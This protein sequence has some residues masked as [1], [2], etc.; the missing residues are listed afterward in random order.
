MTVLTKDDLLGAPTG[1]MIPLDEAGATGRL[2]YVRLPKGTYNDNREFPPGSALIARPNAYNTGRVKVLTPGNQERDFPREGG[3]PFD[4]ERERKMSYR[5]RAEAYKFIPYN[6]AKP[7]IGKPMWPAKQLFPY[8]PTDK[9]VASVEHDIVPGSSR[10]SKRDSLV[11][12]VDGDDSRRGFVP[13]RETKGDLA[14]LYGMGEEFFEYGGPARNTESGVNEH[15]L[16]TLVDWDDQKND[17]QLN[18]LGAGMASRIARKIAHRAIVRARNGQFSALDQAQAWMRQHAEEVK[19]RRIARLDKAIVVATEEAIKIASPKIE[20]IIKMKEWRAS[21]PGRM[22]DYLSDDNGL[23]GFKFGG[24]GKGFSWVKG[25]APKPGGPLANRGKKRKRGLFG[26]LGDLLGL[27]DDGLDGDDEDGLGKFKFG[28][29]KKRPGQMVSPQ[30]VTA[31]V[32]E[33]TDQ[34]TQV[35]KRRRKKR[36]FFGIGSGEEYPEYADGGDTTG[37]TGADNDGFPY[38]GD[39]DSLSAFNFKRGRGFNWGRR[40]SPP[41]PS[42]R[43]GR[44]GLF[45]LGADDD[46]KAGLVTSLS[47]D[48]K[49]QQSITNA[50]TGAVTD[51]IKSGNISTTDQIVGAIGTAAKIGTDVYAAK[52]AAKYAPKSVAPAPSMMSRVTTTVLAPEQPLWKRPLFWGGMALLVGAGGFLML[53]GGKKGKGTRRRS[54]RNALMPQYTAYSNRSR[55]WKSRWA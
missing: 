7:V 34:V 17:W 15:D 37:W 21:K 55:R 10:T 32:R 45:G 47:Q 3:V 39:D 1:P 49:A 35:A 52:L 11:V 54:R 43:P 46:W 42:R 41:M 25:G 16:L 5:T 9:K 30:E 27:S 40:P 26:F 38:L 18:D 14:M 28:K 48:P 33:A 29:R 31:N 24:R 6:S 23:D 4:A 8:T 53:G 20:H 13:A 51:A 44:R 2:D 36:G 50:A 19:T 22:A 12:P